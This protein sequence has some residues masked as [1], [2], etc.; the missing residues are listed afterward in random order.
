MGIQV[1]PNHICPIGSL[2]DSRNCFLGAPITMVLGTNW[3]RST[4]STY[5]G[6]CVEVGNLDSQTI[7]VRDTKH[8][9]EGPILSFTQNEWRA[10]LGS[11]KAG[12]LDSA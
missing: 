4:F 3:R 2:S 12:E 10:F 8:H 11:V 1:H 7:G 6:N 9:G 5:N